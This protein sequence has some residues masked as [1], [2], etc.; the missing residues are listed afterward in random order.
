MMTVDLHHWHAQMRARLKPLHDQVA[1]AAWRGDEHVGYQE[2]VPFEV[3][4][5]FKAFVAAEYARQVAAGGLDPGATLTVTAADRVDSSIA[6]DE[7]PDGMTV[8]LQEAAEAMIAVSD[9]TATDLVMREVGVERVRKLIRDLGL[10]ET[11]IP[12]STRS[13]YERVRRDPGWHPV[14]CLTTMD[15]LASFYQRAVRGGALGSAAA[16]NRFLGLLRQED[17]AQGAEWPETVLCFRKS[18][19]VDP[20]PQLAMAMA[21]AF[22]RAGGELVTFAVALN[23]AFPEDAAD[24]E[25]PLESSVRTFSNGLRYGMRALAGV[26]TP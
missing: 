1:F 2:S 26:P 9:N 16:T 14:A 5:A 11:T 23:V 15:E 18:G 17:R 7:V 22:A 19:M 21:G 6:F 12:D 8:S 24:E 10:V 25:S 13:I 4:S 20:P 3:G